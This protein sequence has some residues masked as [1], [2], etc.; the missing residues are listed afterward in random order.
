MLQVGWVSSRQWLF[1]L[2]NV[3]VAPGP[4]RDPLLGPLCSGSQRE[5]GKSAWR[6]EQDISGAKPESGTSHF[7][8]HST[9]RTS[10]GPRRV[11]R[12]RLAVCPGGK[13]KYGGS[14]AVALP[15]PHTVLVSSIVRSGRG[16]RELL[17]VWMLSIGTS[18][19][20]FKCRFWGPP[21]EPEPQEIGSRKF[22]FYQILSV[23]MHRKVKELFDPIVQPSY[24]TD[25]KV[26]VQISALNSLISFQS[27]YFP[28]VIPNLGPELGLGACVLRP[29]LS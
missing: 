27:P 23:M 21:A 29:I 4:P 18:N 15:H 26:E 3:S 14:S 12:C 28:P 7:G 16:L 1:L 5:R 10:C 6:I 13:G 9:A 24:F 25:G 19:D 17:Q 11:G 8:P 22:Y 2:L 20:L